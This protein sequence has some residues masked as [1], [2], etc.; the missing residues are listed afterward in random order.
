[1]PAIAWVKLTPETSFYCH[2]QYVFKKKKL[3]G[4]YVYTV[5]ENEVL[6]FNTVSEYEFMELVQN[7][8]R[9][10]S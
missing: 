4:Y 7:I 5:W 8:L 6:K 2:D 10:A 3:K 1:M 9:E